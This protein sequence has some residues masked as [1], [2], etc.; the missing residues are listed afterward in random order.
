[1]SDERH[2]TI[3]GEILIRPATA[4]D[5]SAILAMLAGDP[6][7]QM[8][9]HK[10][11]DPDT[12]YR[13]AF[14]DIDCDQRNH[15]LVAD[16]N[17]EVI[18]CLQLTF[19]PGLTYTGRE[20]AQIEGV[21]VSEA[22]RGWGIGRRLVDHAVAKA[23]ARGC[24]LVQLTSDKRRPEAIAFYEALDFELSHEGFKLWLS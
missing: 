21:R 15:I 18:G 9:E 2:N 14:R 17:G 22:A 10:G 12:A 5:L 6:L 20:R 11:A 3:D 16:R 1:M 19:I 13:A 24:V 8:R 23:K 4:D 7:G